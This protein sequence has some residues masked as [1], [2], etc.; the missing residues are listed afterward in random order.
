[1]GRREKSEDHV[2]AFDSGAELHKAEPELH[3]V[4]V[5]RR[6][7]ARFSDTA[8]QLWFLEGYKAARAVRDE[9]LRERAAS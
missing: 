3:L 8:G 9:F 7:S 5:G 4:E 2:E 1:M 6:A